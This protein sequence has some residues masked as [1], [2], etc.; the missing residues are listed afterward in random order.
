MVLTLFTLMDYGDV[1]VSYTVS[2][3]NVV[4]VVRCTA[5]QTMCMLLDVPNLATAMCKLSDVLQP[6][7][8][9]CMLLAVTYLAMAMCRLSYVLPQTKT[10]CVLLDVAYLSTAMCRLLDALQPTETMCMLLGVPYLATAMCM[11]PGA[12]DQSGQIGHQHQLHCPCAP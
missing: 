1:H 5:T 9:M 10:M 6:A 4:Q 12:G 2:D 7:E 3:K 11:L 8:T